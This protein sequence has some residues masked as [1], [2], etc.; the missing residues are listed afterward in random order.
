MYVKTIALFSHHCSL[1]LLEMASIL[2]VCE[3][4]LTTGKKSE[5]DHLKSETVE[6]N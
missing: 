3:I 5:I 2:C 4:F 6:Q 1:P